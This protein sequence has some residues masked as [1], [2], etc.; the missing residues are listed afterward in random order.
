MAQAMLPVSLADPMSGFFALPRPLVEELAPRLTATGF[1][2]LVDILLSADR[3]LRVLELP[4]SFR[5]RERGES[6]LDLGVL[7]EFIGL[8]VDKKLG[9]RVP[10]R[11]L[12]FCASGSVGLLA[13]VAVLWVL[14][15]LV[16]SSFAMAQ[17]S[18]TL[19]AMTVN[20]LLNNHVTYRDRKLRGA[21]LVQGLLLFY[22][23]CGVGAVANVGVAT[24][25]LQD[26]I[27]AWGAAGVAGALITVV[28]N[29]AISSSLVWPSAR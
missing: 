6:K 9:G 23:V 15:G 29:Y 17:A 13:H 16:G 19:A 4:Y 11:F 28:W 2:I 8:L 27:L 10:P 22:L 1:K 14:N 3:S 5:P 21:A 20:F 7:V 18:A 25:L 12:S 26:H 24:L